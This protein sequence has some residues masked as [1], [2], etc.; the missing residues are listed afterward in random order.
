MS[1]ISSAAGEVEEYPGSEISVDVRV[2]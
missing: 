2:C 1:C